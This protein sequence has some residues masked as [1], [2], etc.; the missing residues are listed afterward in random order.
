MSFRPIYKKRSWV[1]PLKE[2][3]YYKLMDNA[4][5]I[6]ELINN[7][8]LDIYAMSGNPSAIDIIEKNIQNINVK[9]L[10]LNPA[11]GHLFKKYDENYSYLLPDYNVN[12][13]E[14][15]NYDESF[16]AMSYFDDDDS[17]PQRWG[18]KINYMALALNPQG[19][20][21]LYKQINVE[22]FTDRNIISNL[23]W[24]TR[25]IDI[26]E[27]IEKRNVNLLDFEN[28]TNNPN[29]VHIIERN[30]DKI[31]TDNQWTN[32]SFNLNAVH[33]MRNNFTKIN[34]Y[35]M[36]QNESNDAIKLLLENP[37]K[38]VWNMINENRNPKAIELLRKNSEKVNLYHLCSNPIA[39]DLLEEYIYKGHKVDRLDFDSLSLNNAIFILDTEKMKKQINNKNFDENGNLLESFAEELIQKSLH[40]DRVK[41]YLLEFN[42]DLLED[43]YI[44]DQ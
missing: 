4:Y 25:A 26:L 15:L 32:L 22:Q 18:N 10:S 28:L 5:A 30:M 29:A 43:E 39:I 44:E 24:N 21:H 11:A 27:K 33:I 31:T 16:S 19:L 9:A 1:P 3:D 38:I 34:W 41:K 14:N 17:Y 12:Y 23:C 42:Y 2:L 8:M 35:A 13:R 7:N 37:D 20:D 40:P 6:N 36:S